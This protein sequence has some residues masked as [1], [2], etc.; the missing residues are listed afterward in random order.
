M[1]VFLVKS[2]SKSKII[3]ELKVKLEVQIESRLKKE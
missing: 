2:L 1:L 3:C